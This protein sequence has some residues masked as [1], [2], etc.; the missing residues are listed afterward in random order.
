MERVRDGIGSS[1]L[2]SLLTVCLAL[3]AAACSDNDNKTTPPK[4]GG[5]DA[6][7]AETGGS[8]VPADMAPASEAGPDT[9]GDVT[10]DAGADAADAGGDAADAAPGTITQK[11]ALTIIVTD[12]IGGDGGLDV[13]AAADALGVDAGADAA[14]G[15]DAGPTLPSVDPN[16]VNPW[17]LAFN[18]TAGLIWTADNGTGQATVYSA[19][20]V[21][22][23]LVVTVAVPPD[24]GV[25]PSAPTGLVF[26]TTAADFNGDKFIFSSEDGTIVGWQTGMTTAVRVDNSGASAKYKGLALGASAG[27]ERLFATD[28]HNGKV[29][30]FDATYAKVTPAGG[31]TDPNLPAGFAPFGI[32]AV[33]VTVYVT[34]AKQDADKKDDVKGAGNGYVDLFDFDGHLVRRVA[35]AGALNSPWGVAIA[36][37][38]F[39]AFSNALLI[40]NFGDGRV[41]A[42]TV[43]TGFWLGSALDTSGA[44]LSIDGLWSIVF[45]PDT[46]GAPHNRLF[47]TAGPGDEN[48]GLLGHLD[49]P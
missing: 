45:G 11:L 26:S 19:T 33:G 12:Q 13:G 49:L 21:V 22:Q 48:H 5:N 1:H 31:F 40:G 47:F 27:A 20:G 30:V 25:P 4:D 39:G 38:D 44:P 14:D 10:P 42:Y 18:T 28:F 24:G 35:S 9:S 17:G 15:G 34:F 43:T 41:N 8:D 3:G 23:P 46:A 29:D 37:A 16:L 2:V 7:K 6:P 32:H 36:P